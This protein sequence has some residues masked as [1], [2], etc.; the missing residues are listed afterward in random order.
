[1]GKLT[2]RTVE[3]L[4]KA[5]MPGMTNDGDGLYLKIGKTGGASWIYRYRQ[6]GRLR[7]M[8][9]GAYPGVSLAEA[10]STAFE[11]RRITQQGG[12]PIGD[13]RAQ[14][15]AAEDEA[16]RAI[17]FSELGGQYIQAHRAGWKNAKHAQQWAN[18]LEQ[19]AYPVIGKLQPS[20]ISTEHVLRIL[21]PI[22]QT[23]TE[24]ASRVRNRIELIWDS[25][26]ARGIASGENPARWRGHLDA[27]L[28]NKSK[29]TK[30]KRHA[31]MPYQQ[32][33]SFRGQIAELE[34]AGARALELIILTACRAGEALGARWDEIDLVR[35][36]WAIPPERMK[37]GRE[38]RIPLNKQAISLLN[39]LPRIQ[40]S[41]YVFPGQ[42]PGR[43]LSSMSVA[44]IMQ[45]R[46]NQYTVH[47]FRSSFRDWAAERTNYPRE[48]CELCLAHVVA[49]GAEAAYWRGDALEKR[50]GLM[51]LWGQ[52]VTDEAGGVV[53]KI[54]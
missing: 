4:C 6:A 19:Y 49:Q 27:L 22:W 20:E 7:D 8:G 12:D 43:P 44:A 1:M 10:R 54:A 53:I 46:A 3:G 31:A 23:K 21:H 15:R 35:G 13:R 11:A 5:G 28:P 48:I 18:T 32:V 37:A 34:S 9:L 30:V 40:G 25:A 52:Y 41:P 50:R 17:T 29:V 36:E 24:T 39:S 42:R 47:G 51:E 26:K 45:Q 14:A 2:T 33:A 38:H 16:K